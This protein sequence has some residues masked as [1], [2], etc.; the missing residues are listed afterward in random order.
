M[1]FPLKFRPQEDYKTR[2]RHF[3]CRRPHGRKHAG[4]D[5]YAAV[6]SSIL[7]VEDGIVKAHKEFYDSTWY[8]VVDHGKFVVRYG[9]IKKKL[10]PDIHVGGK[11]KRGQ[12]IAYVGHLKRLNMSMLHFEMYRGTRTGPL[13]DKK[14]KR[15]YQRRADLID[16]TPFLD[17][18]VLQSGD[19][20]IVKDMDLG[21][22]GNRF[23]PWAITGCF[24]L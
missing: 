2:P 20:G 15:G 19:V 3:G 22:F 7:A 9:E 10:P 12:V 17:Q 11:V 8:L 5:L 23:S 24:R 6:G 1:L 13:T 21:F 16:P 14:D 18:A 4:C